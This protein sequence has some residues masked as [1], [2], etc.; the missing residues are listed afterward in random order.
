[1]SILKMRLPADSNTSTRCLF[2][3]KHYDTTFLSRHPKIRKVVDWACDVNHEATAAPAQPIPAQNPSPLKPG[4]RPFYRKVIDFF[5]D[6]RSAQYAAWLVTSMTVQ[7]TSSIWMA[8]IQ[9]PDYLCVMG[10]FALSMVGGLLA[11]LGVQKW[12]ERGKSASFFSPSLVQT[13]RKT[14]KA[15]LVSFVVSAPALAL[16]LISGQALAAA[17]VLQIVISRHA[18]FFI[19]RY[20]NRHL[21]KSKISPDLAQ[22][23]LN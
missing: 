10:G 5:I 2:K 17:I 14:L 16:D 13:A 3:F 1:M 6:P 15:T 21:K 9:A 23:G 18:F 8:A 20:Y 4:P 7:L 11:K 12:M 22:S 19:D